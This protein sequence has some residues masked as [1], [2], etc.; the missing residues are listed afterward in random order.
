MR[1]NKSNNINTDPQSIEL[2]S[3]WRF[4]AYYRGGIRYSHKDNLRVIACKKVSTSKG[5]KWHCRFLLKDSSTNRF[6]QKSSTII[7]HLDEIDEAI[8]EFKS[9]LSS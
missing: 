5:E 7:D 1:N 2:P 6:N 9:L 3:D 8:I 4:N